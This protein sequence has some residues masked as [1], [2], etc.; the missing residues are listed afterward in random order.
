MFA[1]VQRK[2]LA[3]KQ[4]GSTTLKVHRLDWVFVS[5]SHTFGENFNK[6]TCCETSLPHYC[7]FV[8][9]ER[10]LRRATTTTMQNLFRLKFFEYLF[11]VLYSTWTTATTGVHILVSTFHGQKVFSW[12]SEM[13]Y[14]SSSLGP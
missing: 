12:N 5:F 1:N 8:E 11:M 13:K 6:F 10:K 14:R 7:Q 4:V 9:E 3:M 2:Y